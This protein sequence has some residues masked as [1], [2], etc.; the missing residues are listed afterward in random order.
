MLDIVKHSSLRSQRMTFTAKKFYHFETYG[1]FH[2]HFTHITYGLGKISY[3]VLHCL[4]APTQCFQNALAY[5]GTNIS[6]TCK[7]FMKLTPVSNVINFFM[8]VS[9]DVL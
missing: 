1:Q 2:T 8:A 4:H 5:F 3:T 7:M 9:F 6:Y